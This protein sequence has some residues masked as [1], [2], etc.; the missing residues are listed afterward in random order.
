MKGRAMGKRAWVWGA[1][2][3]KFA[4]APHH[5]RRFAKLTAVS[6]R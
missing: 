6:E 2:F 5:V 3:I 4:R 1:L